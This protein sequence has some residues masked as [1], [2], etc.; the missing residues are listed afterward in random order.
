MFIL[1]SLILNILESFCKLFCLVF[2]ALALVVILSAWGPIPIVYIPLTLTSIAFLIAAKTS[3]YCSREYARKEDTI[4][5]V[6]NW[7]NNL[8][9]NSENLGQEK[10]K[11]VDQ[12]RDIDTPQRLA[13]FIGDNKLIEAKS[14]PE[15]LSNFQK[16]FNIKI[17]DLGKNIGVKMQS[18]TSNSVMDH[19]LS[20]S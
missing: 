20:V 16:E 6:K 10:Q 2:A 13:I 5:Q 9:L 15:F 14:V 3:K 12:L 17:D 18:V 8:V 7:A 11:V 4:Q 1:K 19:K